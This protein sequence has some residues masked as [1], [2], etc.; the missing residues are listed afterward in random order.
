MDAPHTSTDH[1]CIFIFNKKTLV[2]ACT[3]IRFDHEST[4]AFQ[5]NLL[6][7]SNQQQSLNITALQLI[8]SAY[9]ATVKIW[10]ENTWGHTL[11]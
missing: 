2:H 11:S 3:V 6:F 8:G 9:K 4:M 1:E 5:H 7:E 10:N